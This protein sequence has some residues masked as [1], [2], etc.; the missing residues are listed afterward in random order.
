[1]QAATGASV[2]MMPRSRFAGHP[3]EKR[4]DIIATRTFD[5]A[6]PANL[7]KVLQALLLVW[8]FLTAGP[9]GY[10]SPLCLRLKLRAALWNGFLHYQW[11]GPQF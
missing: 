1:M 10:S 11:S 8:P 6:R 7:L 3:W 9:R 4:G 2:Y 5:V